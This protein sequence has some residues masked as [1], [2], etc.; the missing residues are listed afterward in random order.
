MSKNSYIIDGTVTR[1]RAFHD[2]CHETRLLYME[3]N[4]ECDGA[5]IVSNPWLTCDVNHMRYECLDELDEAG[6]V[7]MHGELCFITDFWKVNSARKWCVNVMSK[8]DAI[9]SG[10]IGFEGDPMNSRYVRID[11]NAEFTTVVLQGNNECSLEVLTLKVK[12]LSNHESKA[13]LSL[14]PLSLS[15]GDDDEPK[16]TTRTTGSPCKSRKDERSWPDDLVD[17]KTGIS[18]K[19]LV[20]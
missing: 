10:E 15:Q 18:Y 4:G 7:I 6:V 8:C 3:L 9:R 17:P 5:G 2:L 11:P 12:A 20:F 1:S 19:D 14:S 13:T 16:V